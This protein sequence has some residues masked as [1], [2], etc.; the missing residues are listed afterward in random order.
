[1]VKKGLD[2]LLVV[3]DGERARPVRAPQAPIETP[4]VEHAGERVPYVRERIR[5]L[6]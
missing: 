6:R 1:V 4:G 5:L 2:G 3:H